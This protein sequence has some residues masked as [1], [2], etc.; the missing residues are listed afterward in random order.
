MTSEFPSRVERAVASVRPHLD[1]A[2]KVGIVL[3]SGLSSLAGQFGGRALPFAEIAGFPAPTVQ[4][5][6]GI[7]Q[8][9]DRALVLAGRFHYYEGH[10]YD[11]VC[12]PV[13]LLAGLGVETLILT[14]AA[15]GI[16][17]SYRS[18]DLVMISDHVNLQG[19]NP[20][21]G[22]HLAGFGPRFCD[23]SAVYDPELRR[24]AR[25]IDPELRE[26]VYLAVSG[27]CYETPAEI[28]AFRTMG[29]DLVGMSTVPE[30]ILARSLGLRVL[31][32]STVTNLAAGISPQ[33][34]DHQEVVA[35]GKLVERRMGELL[36]RLVADLG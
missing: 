18:G 20:L 14:N 26:G 7:L 15:G 17:Y 31:G 3:G 25:S 9:G 24:L 4:G 6:A 32:L 34:L 28:R 35:V 12:L 27:P 21:V 2:P 11:T 30:A 16:H 10:S 23:M 8:L 19:G 5:H 29:A 33:P 22:P 36:Q 1:S 13:A